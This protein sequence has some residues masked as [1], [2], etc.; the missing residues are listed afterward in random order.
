MTNKEISQLLRNIAAAY[1]LLGDSRFRIMAYQ[2]AADSV[3]NLAVDLRSVW[4]AGNLQKIPG[5]GGSLAQHLDEL[6]TKGE[7]SH[8]TSI[9]KKI[10]A[11]VFDMLKLRN[12]GPKTAYRIAVEMGKRQTL[13]R[14]TYEKLNNI[15]DTHALLELDGFGE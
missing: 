1:E 3:E 11:G 7:S 2:Q 8:F 12:V 14:T 15:L 9:Q 10:P 5:I 6:F 4:E 13:G